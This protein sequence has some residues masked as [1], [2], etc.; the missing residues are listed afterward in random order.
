MPAGAWVMLSSWGAP[1]DC[2]SSGMGWILGRLSTVW[3]AVLVLHLPFLLF[4]MKV[5][6]LGR[7]WILRLRCILQTHRSHR[8]GQR[9]GWVAGVPVWLQK[10]TGRDSFVCIFLSFMHTHVCIYVYLETA[11]FLHFICGRSITIFFFKLCPL[12]GE[13]WI[14]ATFSICFELYFDAGN[15]GLQNNSSYSVWG[16]GNRVRS[17]LTPSANSQWFDP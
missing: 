10:A 8:G 2:L 3:G 7:V 15:L 16:G 5:E 6:V 9:S 13:D 4:Q 11:W 14:Q 12:T 1:R 17:W